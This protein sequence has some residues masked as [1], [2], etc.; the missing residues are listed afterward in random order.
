MSIQNRWIDFHA[1]ILPGV[2]HGCK[3]A[4]M[5]YKQIL[6]AEKHGINRIVA[7]SH[8]YPHLDTVESFLER[9]QEGI[10]RLTSL[11]TEGVDIIPAAE[12]LIC[13]RIDDMPMLNKLCVSGTRTLLLEM[14]F[15]RRWDNNLT[16]TALRLVKD[17]GLTVVLAHADRYPF[18]SVRQLI[19]GGILV[20][21]NADSFTNICKRCLWNRYISTGAV[22]AI[23]SDIH[24]VSGAYKKFEYAAL[25]CEKHKPEVMRNAWRL[26]GM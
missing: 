3:D 14:P 6:L 24:G 1:H 10:D 26:S 9:R 19:D 20:Q 25:W 17:R 4:D 13:N 12:V 2:D 21:L 22:T 11:N 15:D 8:F 16:D 18:Q 23:G 7:T 5:A